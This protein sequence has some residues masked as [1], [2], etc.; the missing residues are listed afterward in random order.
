LSQPQT[1]KINKKILA[2]SPLP[3]PGEDHTLWEGR[4]GSPQVKNKRADKTNGISA[5]AHC[6]T[7]QESLRNGRCRSKKHQLINDERR[8]ALQN[9]EGR[10]LIVSFLKRLE[11]ATLLETQQCTQVSSSNKEPPVSGEPRARRQNAWAT[12]CSL[13]LL[14]VARGAAPSQLSVKKTGNRRAPDA[15]A[16][17]M[18]VALGELDGFAW[19]RNEL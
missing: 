6:C 2:P 10:A 1:S 16:V 11:N 12:W 9:L 19:V 7:P 15:F 3:S 18:T 17:E 4:K 13:V 8:R 14:T 5:A